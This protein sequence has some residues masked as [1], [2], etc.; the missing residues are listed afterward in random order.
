MRHLAIALVLVADLAAGAT[1]EDARTAL[2]DRDYARATAI[3]STLKVKDDDHRLYLLANA[4]YLAG[5]A[6]QAVAAL[7]ELLRL[8]PK[9]PWRRKALF[10]RADALMKLGRFKEAEEIYER[11]VTYL[12]SAERR[13]QLERV[14][15]THADE[16]F[17]PKPPAGRERE[18]ALEQRKP[19]YAAALKLYQ[20]SAELDALPGAA[21][22]IALRIGLCHF[23]LR[24]YPQAIQ[25]L[26]QMVEKHPESGLVP[27]ALYHLGLAHLK[28]GDPDKAR[29]Y[30]AKLLR[31][32]ADSPRA[33]DALYQVAV[34][35]GLPKPPTEADLHLGAKALRRF[36][37]LYPKHRL[38]PKAGY[39]IGLAYFN[40]GQFEKAIEE[41]RAFV[42]AFARSEAPEVGKAAFL[43][44]QA[45]RRLGHFDE[46]IAAWR[47][48]LRRFPAHED[49]QK[50]QAAIVSAR[51]GHAVALFEKKQWDDARKLF[52][53]FAAT[54]PLDPRNDDAL[55][56]LGLIP[57]EQ[58]RYQ[59][60]VAAWRRLVATFPTSDRGRE[61][62]FR[63]AATLDRDLHDF[64]AAV[65]EYKKIKRGPFAAEAAAR[66]AELQ[67]PALSVA[68]ERSYRTDE[69][70][71]L[72]A[73]TRN[74]PKL[75]F[76]AYRL[77]AEDFFRRMA[78]FRD[79]EDLDI[80][81]IAPHQEWDAP[82]KNFRKYE[83]IESQLDL[84][85]SDPGLYAVQVSAEKLQATT[86][87]LITD[88]AI[89]ARVS[90]RD[91]L[92]FAQNTRT[93]KPQ[94][95]ARLLVHD[96]KKV[97]LEGTTDKD[98]IFKAECKELKEPDQVAVFAQAG[99]GPAYSGL[100]LESLGVAVG[101]QPRGVLYTD[102]PAYR[103]GEKVHYR[104]IIRL[105]A[106]GSYSTGEGTPVVVKAISPRGDV[107][108][109]AKLRLSRFGTLAG[110]FALNPREPLG[111]WR[112]VASLGRD[113]P[114]FTGTFRVDE[115]SL[116]LYRVVFDFPK[117]TYLRGE[118][119][120]GKLRVEY[121]FGRPVAGKSLR[122]R[123]ARDRWHTA[124]TDEK[125]EVA[126]EL[127]T[128]FFRQTA[129]LPLVVLMPAEGIRAS[130]NFLLAT[131]EFKAT[132][133]TLR[134]TYLVGEP[135]DVEVSTTDLEG[136]PIA[137]EVV[138]GLYRYVSK[139]DERPRLPARGPTTTGY[140][141]VAEKKVATDKTTGKATVR[142]AAK[143]G[144]W[145][146][147][148][149]EGHDSHQNLVVAQRQVFVSGDD[150]EIKLRILTDSDTYRV[151]EKPTVNIVCRVGPAT[152]LLT[153]EGERVY[154]Y[155]VVRLKKGS[156]R[157]PIEIPDA[158]APNF[159]L[160]AGV[161]HGNAFHQ[162]SKA[163]AVLKELRVAIEPSA[164]ELKPGEEI[165][166][167]LTAT[168][169]AGRPVQAE[170]SLA[171]VDE[172]LY[173]RYRD[174]LP[175]LGE[176]FHQRRR[177][178]FYA[179][180]A[181]SIFAYKAIATEISEALLHEEELEFFDVGGDEEDRRAER[182]KT[183]AGGEAL[184]FDK[185]RARRS[186][187]YERRFVRLYDTDGAALEDAVAGGVL[188]ADKSL[189]LAGR[190]AFA[191]RLPTNGKAQRRTA[192]VRLR[193]FFPQTAYWNPAIHTDKRGKAT[194]KF[195]MPDTTT[196]WR[197]VARGVTTD[198]LVGEATASI[199]TR[200]PFSVELATP[201][202]LTEG[203]KASVRASVRN[204]TE[205]D[206]SATL[207]VSAT[208]D[209]KAQARRLERKV[210]A[211]KVGED[212]VPIQ[213][214]APGLL[215]VQVRGRAGDLADAV[216]RKLTV[217][218][219]GIPVRTGTSGRARDSLTLDLALPQP[220]EGLTYASRSLAVVISPSLPHDLLEACLRTHAGMGCTEQT[221]AAGL[222]A[223]NA[224]ELL[225]RLGQAPP[226]ERSRL[227]AKVESAL[228]TLALTQRN[229]GWTWATDSK[230]GRLDP[231]ATAYALEFCRRAQRKGFAVPKKV[232]EP[233]RAAAKR[234]FAT[235]ESPAEKA[236]LLYG[237][238]FWGDADFSYVNRLDRLHERL[239]NQSLALLAL[240][241]LN[242]DRRE[243]ATQL[244]AALLARS[245]P[246]RLPDGRKGRHIPLASHE[247]LWRGDR[248]EATALALEALERT[249]PRAPEVEEL[250]NWLVHTRAT[251]GWGSPRA[252]A[253]VVRALTT[254]LGE[255]KVAS[256]KFV[257]EIVLNGK[258]LAT[259]KADGMRRST[260]IEA[261]AQL[262]RDR[263]RLDFRFRGRGEF[264]YACTLEGFTRGVPK[265]R[266][267]NDLALRRR[268]DASPMLFEGREV[269]RGYSVVRGS[270]KAI[271]NPVEELPRKKTCD[272][273]IEVFVR[274]R[275]RYLVLQDFLPAGTTIIERTIKGNFDRYELGRAA[276][277]FYFSNPGRS[278][279][280]VGVRTTVTSKHY[281]CPFI[282]DCLG[283]GDSCPATSHGAGV[284]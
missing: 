86:L 191:D 247:A 88:L 60:A 43:V 149:L 243:R 181:S 199:V 204:F 67:R 152:A 50:A 115:Y 77:D 65:A 238:S 251:T 258:K 259:V 44:G 135:F 267:S 154:R 17:E 279:C 31:D 91:V 55:F 192:L 233:A 112:L 214:P 180:A 250:V 280:L 163:L 130:R 271:A 64:E 98:G 202:A 94:P 198:H 56:Y 235:A 255:A 49:W 175:P 138:V 203:D 48:Y 90:R 150:D 216:A 110:E 139:D 167:E 103:P 151:G 125:G 284:L 269:P 168:D 141:K 170:L 179:A 178:E 212:F 114:T 146:L 119:I 148:R 249:N 185:E 5:H 195:V 176:F 78:G 134:Q 201:A 241:F 63:I 278:Q 61:A 53:Q 1:L 92:V 220:P 142:F 70:P 234:L 11:E 22:R 16:A 96:G 196:S 207:D 100:D 261:P 109:E 159:T 18:A 210:A 132:L 24:Q 228:R 7:D 237:M 45:H 131:E 227:E 143:A 116:P 111:T 215:E 76:K 283:S 46:A 277:T 38:A 126:V 246:V 52:E 156:N 10:K 68:F 19:D 137:A 95:G 252:R 226:V 262:V 184:V 188:D 54:Y 236:A 223:I 99:G 35:H 113:K 2:A 253:A 229:G 28:R 29:A 239:D 12:A 80:A 273:T 73:L 87:V 37:K 42:K 270:Y 75:H 187:V 189:V 222:L 33:P 120:A 169:Q 127:E 81:L 224:I 84:P 208:L 4:H 57:Y 242:L 133:S 122:Y 36:V 128:D 26:D 6:Q 21:P 218:P 244:A 158:C 140:A 225:D 8:H 34:A 281:R 14:Y 245:K 118:K 23:H 89:I 171:V 248:I 121:F 117:F 51:F 41:S 282:S 211:G 104:G 147:L 30:F 153:W 161:V 254:Y 276:I 79:V 264:V 40:F 105:V 27:E 155:R 217:R 263:N 129:T 274:Q 256:Q 3:L 15:L 197:L 265:P 144:G 107:V 13:G 25:C 71:R 74:I 230:L 257:L 221:I 260:R 174:R 275:D 32:H 82:I 166:V 39:E 219:W 232:I 193:E 200:Q 106:K 145:H 172:A 272:V 136:K 206:L 240:T 66:L 69:K 268:Y 97:V 177:G 231:F 102:R 108:H 173:A 205:R 190:P 213:A 157:I 209:G 93:G 186:R 101:I 165:T 182:S 59:D 183:A 9:S 83:D 62:Q 123:F 47:N 164:K 124:T 85:F 72:K 58:K 266:K 162:A 194:V 160:W 20:R